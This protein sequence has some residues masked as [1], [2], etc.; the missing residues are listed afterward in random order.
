MSNTIDVKQV[1]VP[2]KDGIY[3]I[4]QKPIPVDSSTLYRG[5][6]RISAQVGGSL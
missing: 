5:S 2:Q 6:N 1:Y 3:D 4:T